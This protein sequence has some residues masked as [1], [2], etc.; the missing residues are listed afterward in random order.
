MSRYSVTTL[1]KN[2]RSSSTAWPTNAF[3]A[4]LLAMSADI[5]AGVEGAVAIAERLG[6]SQLVVGLTVVA[7]GTSAPEAAA[8]IAAVTSGNRSVGIRV[9]F[10]D[11]I[12][13]KRTHLIATAMAALAVVE[14]SL[15]HLKSSGDSRHPD[16]ACSGAADDE[17]LLPVGLV[18]LSEPDDAL[19]A[20]REALEMGCAAIMVPSDAPG[21]RSPAHVDFEPFWATLA[22]SGK[23]RFSICDLDP[24]EAF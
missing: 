10:D 2:L 9:E 3:V 16:L 12:D 6:V 21:S 20:L 7:M 4:P 23:H 1:T 14:T 22:A 18:P 5:L 8:S 19:A 24:T 17:R 13:M 11:G 15:R